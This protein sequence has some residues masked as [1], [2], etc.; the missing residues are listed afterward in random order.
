MANYFLKHAG[1]EDYS[2]RSARMLIPFTITFNA[3]PASKLHATDLP[4]VMVLASEGLT[5]AAAA[6]DTGTNFTTPVDATGIFGVLLANLGSV[7]KLLDVSLVN[8][9]SGT[10]AVSRVGASSSGVTASSNIAVSVDWSGNLATTSLTA[11]L[12][13]DYRI[14]K[15]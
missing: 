4:G 12:A 9:S 7:E 11:T 8:L 13:V 1:A 15:N 14:S 10:A 5:A 3:T 2:L 6:V